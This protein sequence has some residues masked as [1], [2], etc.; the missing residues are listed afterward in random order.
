MYQLIKYKLQE[1]DYNMP[2]TRKPNPKSQKEISNNQIDPYTFPE[3]GKSYGN[4]NIPS[5]Y[6]QFTNNFQ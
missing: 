3:S 6:K 5:D 4:P 2:Q 1:K